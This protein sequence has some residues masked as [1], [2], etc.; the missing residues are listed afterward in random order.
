[1]TSPTA[2]VL[3]VCSVC[4]A[5]VKKQDPHYVEVGGWKRYSP[6]RGYRTSPVGVETTGRVRCGA[7]AGMHQGELPI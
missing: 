7:C 2:K 3:G 6:S 5:P 4:Q 1:M